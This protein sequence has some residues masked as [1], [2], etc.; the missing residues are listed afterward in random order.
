MD[1]IAGR[2][3]KTIAGAVDILM[4]DLS[5]RDKTRIANMSE[6]DLIQFHLSYGNYIRTE[7]R[8]PGNDPLMQSCQSHAGIE[9]MSG[10]QASFVILKALREKVRGSNV[11]RVVK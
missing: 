2:F 3:P 6:P 9:N 11:L 10:L 8:L 1:L 4:A 7:F 5:F